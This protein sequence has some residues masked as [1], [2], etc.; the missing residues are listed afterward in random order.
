MREES[1]RQFGKL[2]EWETVLSWKELALA[3]D[4]RISHFFKTAD[5]ADDGR[6]FF[7]LSSGD[8]DELPHC[9]HHVCSRAFLERD[10]IG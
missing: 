5:G 6:V 8:L 9:A 2:V 3:Y 7:V 4:N 10:Q 1:G